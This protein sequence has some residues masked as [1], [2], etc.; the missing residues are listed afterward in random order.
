MM[1][2]FTYPC[3]G[4][5]PLQVSETQNPTFLK[6]N[7]NIAELHLKVSPTENCRSCGVDE[8]LLPLKLIFET[9]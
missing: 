9:Q 7:I 3:G 1:M 6:K 4:P 5:T 8:G 2:I